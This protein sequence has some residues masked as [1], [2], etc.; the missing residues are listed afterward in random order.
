M[1]TQS[2]ISPLFGDPR[3]PAR[4]WAK[5]N[6]M[7][8]RPEIGPCWEWTGG[9][10]GN[11]YGR[12]AVGRGEHPRTTFAPRLAYETLVGAIPD[13]F[14]PDH[15]CRNRACVRPQH[16][17]PVARVVNVHRG[18]LPKLTDADVRVIRAL[19]GRLTQ[20]HIAAWF[21]VD[22]TNIGYIQRGETWAHVR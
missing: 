7:T 12:F 14:E 21:G 15:L 11:G 17:E 22:H 8:Y 16:L 20:R 9:R 6:P 2:T 3:L 10:D 4:F 18:L 1:L 19:R 13:G 5:V